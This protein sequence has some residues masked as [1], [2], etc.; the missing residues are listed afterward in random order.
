MEPMKIPVYEI[1]IHEFLYILKSKCLL[2]LL[3]RKQTSIFV[4]HSATKCVL[5]SV[6]ISKEKGRK[7]EHFNI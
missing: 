2:S 1:T 3:I 4:W 5:D 7:I 6:L